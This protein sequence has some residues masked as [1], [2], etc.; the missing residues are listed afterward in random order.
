VVGIFLLALTI[1]SAW[2]LDAATEDGFKLTGG[3]DPYYHKRVVDYVMENGEHL[4]RD[5]ML[6]YPYGANNNRPPLFDWSIAIAGLVLAPF[7]G[8]AAESTWW[9]MEVLPAVYGALIVFPVY[10][11]G[12]AQF[13]REAGLL[14]AL[15]IAVNSGHVS[16]STLS[17][18]DHDSYIIFFGTCTFFFFMRALTEGNDARWV[19]DWRSGE[20]IKRGFTDFLQSERLALGYA[21]LAGITLV[22]VALSW[23][24]FPYLMVIVAVYLVSQM[25]INAFRRVDSLT[26]AILG[27]VTLS[28]P[29]LL[30]FPY[31]STMGFI[32]PWWDAPAYILLA[33]IGASAL[34]VPTRDLPWLLV[35]GGTAAVAA[36]GYLLLT[37]VFVDLGFLL[38]SGQGYFVRTKLFDTIAEAQPPTFANFI[39]SFGLVSVWFGVFGLIWMAWQ[40]FANRLWK[41]DYLF[42][43]IWAFVALYMAQSAIRFIFNATPV[44]ALLSGWVTWLLI[45]NA[46]FGNVLE[47]WRHYW[48]RHGPT[49]LF[50]TLGSLLVGFLTIFTVGLLVG[51][52]VGIL[53]L[54]LMLSIGHMA[55]GE[56]QYSLRDRLSG[57]HRAFEIKRP[58]IAFVV[59]GMLL[60]PNA[61]YGYDAAVPYEDK[62]DHDTGVYDF[63]RYS[64]LRPDEYEYDQRNNASLYPEGVTGMYNR[65]ETSQ[66][67]YMGISGPSFPASYWIDGL[68]WLAEQDTE[69]PQEKRPG[70]ISWW[71]YGFWSI[72]IGEHPTV[73]DNFQFGYQLAGNFI[74]AQGE[75]DA[76]ALLLY[77]L[78]EPEVD[79]ES[80]RF[81]PGIREI[82]LAYYSEDNVTAL[83]RI[84]ANPGEQV[85]EGEDINK[86]NA[87]IRAGRPI[88]ASVS[89]AELADAIYDIEQATGHSIR[90]FGADTRLMPYSAENTGILY[91]PVTL[92]DYELNDFVA[93]SLVLSN[94][95]TVSY[96]EADELLRNDPS[97]SVTSQTLEYKQRFLDSMFYRAFIG[98]SGPDIGREASDGIPGISGEIG[99]DTSLPPLP[100]WGLKHFKLVYA[101]NGLRI[102]K[103][104]DGATISG[105]VQTEEG[106]PVPNAT[107]TL[108]DEYSTPHDSVTT[109][110][111]GRYSIVA[112]AGNHTLTVSMGE[113]GS[114]IERLRLTS[115]NILAR[116]EGILISEA[117]ATRATQPEIRV[118]IKVE[119]ASLSGELYWDAGERE[120][121][122]GIPV[123]AT[124][125]V[126]GREFSV[127]SGTDG[128]FAFDAIAPGEYRVTADL[129]GHELE[130]A[131]YEGV[132]GLRAD[133]SLEIDGA[134]IGSTVLGL[135]D[136]S[137]ELTPQP[138]TITLFDHTNSTLLRREAQTG[139]RF[140]NLLPGNYTL[141]LEEDE[142]FSDWSNNT[143]IFSLAAGKESH[144][145]TTLTAG[146]RVSGTLTWRGDP[147][148]ETQISITHQGRLHSEEVETDAQGHFTTILPKGTYDFYALHT[149]ANAAW[150]ARVET[151][152]A[153]ELMAI[154]QPAGTITGK[155]F[156]DLDGDGVFEP[157]SNERDVGGAEVWLD[158]ANGRLT[159]MSGPRGD[160]EALLPPGDYTAYAFFAEAEGIL[161]GLKRMQLEY[162]TLE[163]DLPLSVGHD[164]FVILTEEHLGEERQVGG[165]FSLEATSGLL[166]TWTDEMGTMLPLPAGNYR[167]AIHLTGYES[168]LPDDERYDHFGPGELQFQLL[169]T[170]VLVTGTVVHAGEPLA[171]AQISFTPA[172]RPGS[173]HLNFSTGPDGK[174]IATLPPHDYY[175]EATLELGGELYAASGQLA[176]ELGS[177]PVALGEVATELLLQV[178]GGARHQGELREGEV[179][180]TSTSA[181]Y[182]MTRLISTHF[183]GYHG[184]LPP[185]EYWVTFEGAAAGSH[186]SHLSTLDLTMPILLHD[187]ALAQGHFINGALISE[188]TGELVDEDVT[189]MFISELGTAIAN[190]N[191]LDGDYGP[192]DLQPGSYQLEIILPGFQSYSA[193]VEVAGSSYFNVDMIPETLPLTLNLTYRDADG[194]LQPLAGVEATFSREGGWSQTWTSDANGTIELPEMVPARYDVSVDDHL[195]DGADQFYL[196]R[197]LRLRAGK[198]HQFFDYSAT[199]KA[200]FQGSVFYDR[201]FDGTPDGDELLA[202]AT[203]EIRLGAGESVLESLE[204]DADGNF[205]IYLK[206]DGYLLRAFSGSGTAYT[207]IE[208]LD[209]NGSRDYN[210]S[211]ERGV[212]YEWH[213]VASDDGSPV[214]FDD[215]R[216]RAGDELLL[217]LVPADGVVTTILP[218]GEYNLTALLEFLDSSPDRIF[219]LDEAI[220][221]ALADDGS[222]TTLELERQLLRGADVTVDRLTAP[223]AVGQAVNFTFNFTGTGHRTTTFQAEVT[224]DGENWTAIFRAPDVE[225]PPGESRELV[226]D[227]T[228]GDGVIPGVYH[229]FNVRFFWEGQELYDDVSFDFALEVTPTERP[230]PDFSI[231]EVTWAPDNIEPGTE[232]TLQATVANTVAGSGEQFPQVGFYLDDEL[233]E[234][235]SVAF[236]GEG[237]SVVEATWVASE[238]VHSFRVE[239]DPEEL[240]SEQDETNNAKPLSLTVKAAAEEAEGFQW[241]MTFM[242]A[243]LLLTIAYF[244]LRLRR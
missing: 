131:N 26:A 145:N 202:G 220:T 30:S 51:F 239:V 109:D 64:L 241:L 24:G 1:R 108:L 11:I 221:L 175:Y 149:D 172:D 34:L 89:L 65:T 195:N 55:A 184:W 135:L 18:A 86:R 158:S 104:Y 199:W 139:F 71:D 152:S 53:L 191:G 190:S 92:A 117:Q 148:P 162:G 84:I 33:F 111:Q 214:D 13:G 237:E 133:Q 42:I 209:F 132:A 171:S 142:Q 37:Y 83:E 73:A 69:L 170:P 166:H 5:E 94:G 79:R 136:R 130:L 47:A 201:N 121:I 43:L 193:P 151:G 213:F 186:Y 96:K 129:N 153:E 21:G 204:T 127:D 244:A 194:V 16:H 156:K 60:L 112:P 208:S 57:L 146:S 226:L 59:V 105:V 219:V 76:L 205:L 198:G 116:E 9:A 15:F 7:F 41:K 159:L 212:E 118:D 31:Y 27:L 128:S 225:V 100:G 72:D 45:E 137:I 77:R 85:P 75:Q 181:P 155:L 168:L 134:V 161:A 224:G 68:E 122:A 236:D 160:F 56:D 81:S 218:P 187:L 143:I 46:G 91:A 3:S 126:T 174:F 124:Q 217:H 35:L 227:I 10:A 231:S 188:P 61:F 240:F 80:D 243:T 123:T 140:D 39:F 107:V 242:V 14:G 4:V 167:P 38:F 78:I 120:P 169:R 234:M 228:P 182:D 99:A 6:N 74:T 110:A 232:V 49:I 87:A 200:R 164:L 216:F 67:W 36:I 12:R 62:K 180:F 70:F 178:S 229:N 222:A 82:M 50:L 215:V 119:A 147:V 165:V 150:L 102:L 90:Y 192:F 235:T 233:I 197:T 223:T 25:V 97:L 179:L 115:N 32:S 177:A 101:N 185:G 22:L 93:V 144:H 141:R 95:Q 157:G 211:L 238:G 176:V 23:K 44:M 103:Y 113:F 66:L 173:Y 58:A 20:S 48:G 2:T 138:L 163:A 29:V 189:L 206:P 52:L 54:A 196:E 40:L 98:W 154:M 207:L 183:S 210:L 230:P 125:T 17:L 203:V 88:L 19:A 63:L 28:L 8:D 114:D 106:A